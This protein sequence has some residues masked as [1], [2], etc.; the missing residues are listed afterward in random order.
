[1]PHNICVGYQ[2][3]ASHEGLGYM[4]TNMLD[5]SLNITNISFYHQF[6]YKLPKCSH[7]I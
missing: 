5:C 4:E 3:W 6:Y 7:N 2:L 1:M